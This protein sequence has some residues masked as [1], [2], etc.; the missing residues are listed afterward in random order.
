MSTRT[1]RTAVVRI[2]GGPDS[3]EIIAVPVADPGPGE[4]RV[5][6][7]AAPVNPVDLAV[8]DGLFHAMKLIDQPEHTG[9]GWGF[10]GTVAATGPGVDL[11]VG[12]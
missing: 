7:A 2:P 10:A 8:A 12:T 1:F 9:L 6:I 11:A 5:G 4:V 3:I